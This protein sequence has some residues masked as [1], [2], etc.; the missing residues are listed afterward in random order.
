MLSRVF[1]DFTVY[2]VLKKEKEI[3]KRELVSTP[4]VVILDLNIDE[5]FPFQCEIV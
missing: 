4:F 3:N 1:V 5:H 2:W